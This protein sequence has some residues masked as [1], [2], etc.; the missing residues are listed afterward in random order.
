MVLRAEQYEICRSSAG[1]SAREHQA[2]M[3]RL[4]MV[5]TGLEAMT[6]G[7]AQAGLVAR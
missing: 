1:F 4:D 6:G 7:H 2:I 3:M 5:T